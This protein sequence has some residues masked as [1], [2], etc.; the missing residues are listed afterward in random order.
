MAETPAV[1]GR[2]SGLPTD[3]EPEKAKKKD[4]KANAVID[5]AKD[6]K[7][8]PTLEIAIAQ[9]MEDQ[10]EFVRWWQE[11]VTPN[12]APDKKRRAALSKEDA[13]KQTGIMQQQVSKWLRRLKEPEKY[14]AML[15]GAAYY[16]AMA[17]TNTTALK[18]TGDPESYT[19][20]KY[21]EAARE[22][23]GGID[24]DPASNRHAQGTPRYAQEGLSDASSCSLSCPTRSA[25]CS[26]FLPI[27]S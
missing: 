20:A 1:I 13:E 24:L 12:R 19:P 16:K 14:Q 11:T 17:E 4:A 8:W 9:K 5:Y 23:M 22:V 25:A 15:F 18:W 10:T 2:H 3:F 26:R 21:I 6:I 27:S 7:N